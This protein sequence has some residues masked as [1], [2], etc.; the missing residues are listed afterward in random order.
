MCSCPYTPYST[1]HSGPVTATTHVCACA[2]M[3]LWL[4]AT[5]FVNDGCQ[6]SS[7]VAACRGVINGVLTKGLQTGI[8]YFSSALRDALIFGAT[9]PEAVALLPHEVLRG[10]PP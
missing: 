7:N 2:C 5:L 1:E 4:Q 6:A 10:H 8:Q 3:W 9:D